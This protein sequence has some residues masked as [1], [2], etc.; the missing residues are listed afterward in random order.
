MKSQMS[1]GQGGFTLIELMI[2]IAIIGILAAIALP[3]Y[4]DYTVRARMSEPL[5]LAA[6]AKTTV[7][8]Y[9]AA[10]G[11]LPSSNTEAGMI[12]ADASVEGETAN[13]KVLVDTMVWAGDDSGDDGSTGTLTISMKE[14][15]Q[16]LAGTMAGEDI[17]VQGTLSSRGT[18][19]WECG[20]ATDAKAKYLPSSCRDLGLAP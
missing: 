20:P 17:V 9:V 8:E 5:A 3:A 13:D 10:N 19:A 2:V 7:S 1:K 4:Q 6:E 14:D 15:A 12:A 18:V 11:E 16:G